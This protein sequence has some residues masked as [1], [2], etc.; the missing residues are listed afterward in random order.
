[1]HSARVHASTC[2]RCY[3]HYASVAALERAERKTPDLRELLANVCSMRTEAARD[4][5]GVE[6]NHRATCTP[7]RAPLSSARLSH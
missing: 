2:A 1:M 7:G 6:R 4:G 5:G 3:H